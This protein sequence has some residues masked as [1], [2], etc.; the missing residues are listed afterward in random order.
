MQSSHNAKVFGDKEDPR[1]RIQETFGASAEPQKTALTWAA[2]T[3]RKA[4]LDSQSSEVAAIA[5]LRKS[6]PKLTL[7]TAAY[8]V[9]C[10]V[11]R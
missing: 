7:T 8:L 3:L 6:E 4:G 2:D 11:H 10:V 5:C 9:S 1:R